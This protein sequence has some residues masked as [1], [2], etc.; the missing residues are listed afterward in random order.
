[1]PNS[2]GNPENI[3]D[4]AILPVRAPRPNKYG[5]VRTTVDGKR[6]ASGKE[7]A[8]YG[9]LVLAEKAGEIRDL[10]CQPRYPLVVNGR[11]VADY[12]ADF[13]Y[14]DREGLRVVEDVKGV[15]TAVYRLKVKLMRACYEIE[16][17]ET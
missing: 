4:T 11:R 15:R 9:Q 7:A 1:M 6:F 17:L 10:E 13:A 8:R 16:V 5:A 3:L 14:R 12:I 2:S